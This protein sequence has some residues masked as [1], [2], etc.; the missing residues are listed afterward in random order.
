MAKKRY[1]VTFKDTVAGSDYAAEVLS[2]D[3]K[4][5][6]DGVELLAA[7]KAGAESE[8]AHFQEIGACVASLSDAE[9]KR[10]NADKRVVEVVEDFEVHAL[11]CRST[12]SDGDQD[13]YQQGYHDALN[14]LLQANQKSAPQGCRHN[15]FGSPAKPRFIC[16]PGSRPVFRCEPVGSEPPDGDEPQP[17][18]WNIEMVRAS[19][20]WER[21]TGRDVKVAIIDTGIEDDHADLTVSG[22]A[23]FVEGVAHWDD[24]QGHGTHCAGITA[25]RNNRTGVVGVAPECE[26]YAVKVLGGDGSGQLSWVLGGM[27]WAQRNGMQVV[28]MSLGSNVDQPDAECVVAYQRAAQQLI[29]ADCIVIAAA[30]NSG[31]QRN[32]W[33]GN[34]A[35]CGGFMAVAAVDRDKQLASFSSN[36]PESL[37]P[38]QGVEI[39]AP[40]VGVNSTYRGGGYRELSGTSMACPHVSGAAALLKELHP[41]WTPDRIRSRLKDTA[42]DLGAPGNDPQHGSGLL[43]CYRAV[44]G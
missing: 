17:I 19:A 14:D 20:V 1:V 5:V 11:G 34:P 39:A 15:P 8:V 10:L 12:M 18:S 4:R 2:V 21:V 28:S 6:K 38:L 24:D 7:E 26:L 13:A 36:G 33:V 44:F 9:Y 32:P 40:G 30:G 31:R 29:D 22:G 27:G 37:G 42:V 35:R 41:T 23:S 3:S 25:A 43:D 16:P